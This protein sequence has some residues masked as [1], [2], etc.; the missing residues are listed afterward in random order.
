[1]QD[2]HLVL[3]LKVPLSVV[4]VFILVLKAKAKF[5]R[6]KKKLSKIKATPH[7]QVMLQSAGLPCG[8]SRAQALNRTN[9]QG[10]KTTDENV[11]CC[12]CY[13]IC[14]RL[15]NLFFSDKDEKPQVPSPKSSLYWLAED[16]KESTHLSQR[17][18]NIAPGVVVWPMCHCQRGIRSTVIGQAVVVSLP[19]IIRRSQVKKQI[20]KRSD[21]SN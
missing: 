16:L 9:T 17:V 13:D 19:K 11:T 15:H 1:M 4:P 10:L 8:R 20:N 6:K 18:G 12:L 2:A 3:R 14:K 5:Q 21:L 7:P